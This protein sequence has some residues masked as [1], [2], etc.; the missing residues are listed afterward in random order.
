MGIY[1]KNVHH[2][3]VSSIFYVEIPC[4]IFSL[5]HCNCILI[6][7][8]TSL[9]L[10]L[11]RSLVAFL[12][13]KINEYSSGIYSIHDLLFKIFLLLWFVTLTLLIFFLLCVHCM[14]IFLRGVY[15]VDLPLCLLYSLHSTPISLANAPC[16]RK[17]MLKP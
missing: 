5:I 4:Y 9:N 11:S 3:T 15:F 7:T 16:S 13:K 2:K 8:I 12:L 17:E 6:V 1:S 10:L 14:L